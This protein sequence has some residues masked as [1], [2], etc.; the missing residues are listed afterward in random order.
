MDYN[1]TV[2]RYCFNSKKAFSCCSVQSK[3]L[4]FLNTSYNNPHLLEDHEMNLFIA[5]THPVNFWTSLIKVV[6]VN[7]KIALICVVLASIPLLITI[8]PKKIPNETV[9]FHFDRLSFML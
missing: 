3:S 1:G 4:S 5:A 9:K 8:C 6:D 2:V 7:S